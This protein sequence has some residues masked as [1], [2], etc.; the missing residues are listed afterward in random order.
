[1]MGSNFA[2]SWMVG[3]E[4]LLIPFEIAAIGAVLLVSVLLSCCLVEDF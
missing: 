3:G 4:V 1:M 2:A